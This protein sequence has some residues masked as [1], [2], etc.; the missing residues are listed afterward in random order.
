MKILTMHQLQ[1]AI[2]STPACHPFVH[3]NA[4][5]NPTRKVMVTDEDG[6]EVEVERKLGAMDKD[7]RIAD[8]LSKDFCVR[9]RAVFCRE[10]KAR[11]LLE[12]GWKLIEA[13]A[14]DAA[15]AMRGLAADNAAVDF[16][17]EAKVL[18]VL[19]ATGAMTEENKEKVLRMCAEPLTPD[20]VSIAIRGGLW[21]GE[22]IEGF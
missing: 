5:P 16:I 4:M 21:Q 9:A 2:A 1:D 17:A 18:D 22:L 7:K 12:G 15:F 13:G 20:V 6:N 10:V 3:T 8:I 11:L 14:S 19:I